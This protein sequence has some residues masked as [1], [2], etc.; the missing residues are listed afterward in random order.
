MRATAMKS[1][2]SEEWVQPSR[3]SSAMGNKNTASRQPGWEFHSN[4]CTPALP[5]PGEAHLHSRP[6]SLKNAGSSGVKCPHRGALRRPSHTQVRASVV[7]RGAFVL[8]SSDPPQANDSR[9]VTGWTGLLLVPRPR[10]CSWE[11]GQKPFLCLLSHT[12]PCCNAPWLP[13][14]R[15][16]DSQPWLQLESFG[17]IK[18]TQTTTKPRPH[19]KPSKWEF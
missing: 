2:L 6:P 13:T 4:S 16:S 17:E 7:G 18:K 1:I 5:P 14:A 15:N 19:P 3:S 8:H 9:T 11:R 10:I 12:T